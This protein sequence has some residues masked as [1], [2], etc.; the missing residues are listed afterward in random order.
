MI[1]IKAWLPFR[2]A[3]YP[4]QGGRRVRAVARRAI[5]GLSGI[6]HIMESV[7]FFDPDSDPPVVARGGSATDI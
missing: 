4:G 1:H 7:S 3:L 5:V 6:D 2:R